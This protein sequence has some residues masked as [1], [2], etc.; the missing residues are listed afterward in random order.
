MK[1]IDK[2]IY[3]ELRYGKGTLTIFS[4]VLIVLSLAMLAG[5]IVLLVFG[6]RSQEAGKMA[7]KIIFGIILIVLGLVGGGFS[8]PML[9]VALSMPNVDEGSVKDG[10]RAIGTANALLCSKCGREIP[11]N[12]VFC[13]NCGTPVEGYTKCEC[14][15]V[16]SND[17]EYCGGCGKKLK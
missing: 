5:G 3:H 4:L 2:N 15:T 13:T 9:F 14:G 11:E 8:L 10:N 17:A 12:T 16:N 7:L 1:K 6:C